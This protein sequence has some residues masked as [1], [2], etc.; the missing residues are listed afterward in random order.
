ML[1]FFLKKERKENGSNT[2]GPATPSAKEKQPHLLFLSANP[3]LISTNLKKL[4]LGSL[5]EF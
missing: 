2:K 1:P 4:A 5:L 3:A